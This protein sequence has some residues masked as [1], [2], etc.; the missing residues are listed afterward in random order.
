VECLVG[1]DCGRQHV[2]RLQREIVRVVERTPDDHTRRHHS[3]QLHLPAASVAGDAAIGV[4][5]SPATQVLH[6]TILASGTFPSLIEYNFPHSTGVQ[7]A[8]NLIDGGILARD[9]ATGTL[10]GNVTSASPALFVNPSAG[11]L[12]LAPSAT[13]AIDRVA[14]VA[15]A[16]TDWDGQAR[17]RGAAADA[18][19]DEHVPSI[20]PSPPQNFRVVY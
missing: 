7:I 12:H 5:D 4:F 3:Q 20:P 11:D 9:G 17:P 14:V 6:N 16:A 18:G 19:A 15:N 2:H 10:S 13:T 8:N 1:H